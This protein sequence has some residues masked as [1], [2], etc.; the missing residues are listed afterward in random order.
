MGQVT[1]SSLFQGRQRLSAV[2]FLFHAPYIELCFKCNGELTV[3]NETTCTYTVAD[4]DDSRYLPG[5]FKC[6]S[7]RCKQRHSISHPMTFIL[8]HFKIYYMQVLKHVSLKFSFCEHSCEQESSTWMFAEN[9]DK[10]GVSEYL[11][12]L[13]VICNPFCWTNQQEID[14]VNA[15]CPCPCVEALRVSCREATFLPAS[16]QGPGTIAPRRAIAFLC[17][18]LCLHIATQVQV[19]APGMGQSHTLC[20]IQWLFLKARSCI[21]FFII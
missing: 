21:Y 6:L 14:S 10:R 20:L 19:R 1:V 8:T 16:G 5:L 3:P 18:L 15:A 2:C 9:E 12:K 4:K 13:I 17:A 11:W 7:T